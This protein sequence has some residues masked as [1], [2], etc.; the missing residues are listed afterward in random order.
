MACLR[1]NTCTCIADEIERRKRK[2]PVL[3]QPCP[4]G[5]EELYLSDMRGV[6]EATP[7]PH[8]R[9]LR[10]LH[11]DGDSH[12]T[13]SQ[14]A[15]MTALQSLN[16]ATPAVC[17]GV[18]EA[19]PALTRL[20]C[21]KLVADRDRHFLSG[22]A[23]GAAAR[24]AQLALLLRQ[25]S[26]LPSLQHLSVAGWPFHNAGAQTLDGNTVL[27]PTLE[28]LHL[29]YSVEIEANNELLA[30]LS[31]KKPSSLSTVRI[32]QLSLGAD[33]RSVSDFDSAMMQ[34]V[35]PYVKV[36]V[37]KLFERAYDPRRLAIRAA[38]G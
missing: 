13:A 29:A 7:E 31:L 2:A 37:H 19:V 32:T 16:A 26:T 1:A 23:L 3:V 22:R 6:W 17:T 35:P 8:I 30:F 20:T 36:I 34:R 4:P 28:V 33:H 27:P 25:L 12:L 11:L 15:A 18:T 10:K 14:L 5:L 9:S 24:T 38:P 21:L